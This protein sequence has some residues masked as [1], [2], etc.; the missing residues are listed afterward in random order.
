M[1]WLGR[2]PH[3]FGL[4][5]FAAVPVV[6]A[7]RMGD[8]A[9]VESLDLDEVSE[10]TCQEEQR[11]LQEVWA[12]MTDECASDE[13]QPPFHVLKLNRCRRQMLFKAKEKL[14]V[15]AVCAREEAAEEDGCDGTKNEVVCLARH[16]DHYAPWYSHTRSLVG[17]VVDTLS[18]KNFYTRRN[19]L[20]T[21]G[22]GVHSDIE[23]GLFVKKAVEK[24]G[25]WK[26]KRST[27]LMHVDP[28]RPCA[29]RPPPAPP[30]WCG[31]VLEAVNHAVKLMIPGHKGLTYESLVEVSIE[32]P[33]ED[34][35]R[36][37]ACDEVGCD[38]I[39]VR[40]LVNLVTAFGQP[41][42]KF[43]E[44]APDAKAACLADDMLDA[45]MPPQ[46]IYEPFAGWSEINGYEKLKARVSIPALGGGKHL[47]IGVRDLKVNNLEG[48]VAVFI[49]RE[50]WDKTEK[51]WGWLKNDRN[52]LRQL[53]F[54]GPTGCETCSNKECRDR[55]CNKECGD[56]FEI[57]LEVT[58]ELMGL[59]SMEIGVDLAGI[60]GPLLRASLTFCFRMKDAPIDVLRATPEELKKH[61]TDADTTNLKLQFGDRL[62][63]VWDLGKSANES[64]GSSDKAMKFLKDKINEQICKLITDLVKVQAFNLA[65]VHV[66]TQLSF[67][68][69]GGLEQIF[70]DNMFLNVLEFFNCNHPDEDDPQCGLEIP[71]LKARTVNGL[72]PP[73]EISGQETS[74][75]GEKPAWLGKTGWQ[76]LGVGDMNEEAIR[77]TD[78]ALYKCMRNIK[79]VVGMAR[80]DCGSNKNK[81]TVAEWD[82]R[83]KK[84]KPKSILFAAREKTNDDDTQIWAPDDWEQP[85]WW[86][87]WMSAANYDSGKDV[88]MEELAY[89][90]DL[91][92]GADQGDKDWDNTLIL[93]FHP[94]IYL[95]GH[96]TTISSN[97][98]VGPERLT[99]LLPHLSST[100]D[101]FMGG[102]LKP[103]AQRRPNRIDEVGTNHTTSISSA[104]GRAP[105]VSDSMVR[106]LSLPL[107]H[108]AGISV[109]DMLPHIGQ[110][111]R[112]D[113][114]KPKELVGRNVKL[115]RGLTI[116]VDYILRNFVAAPGNVDH[117]YTYASAP[118]LWGDK[119]VIA[120][121]NCNIFRI[122]EARPVFNDED[123]SATCTDE[124][125]A[126]SYQQQ[127][128]KKEGSKSKTEKHVVGTCQNSFE[129]SLTLRCASSWRPVI[130][131]GNGYPLH[132]QPIEQIFELW[133]LNMYEEVV[134]DDTVSKAAG[135]N[136][137]A[138]NQG[139]WK[140]KR[141]RK[142]DYA[143][144]T[145]GI[146]W[147][148]NIHG[149]DFASDTHDPVCGEPL[150]DGD[151]VGHWQEDLKKQPITAN[152]VH[153]AIKE[154]LS[155]KNG[156]WGE[157]ISDPESAFWVQLEKFAVQANG[158][159]DG[160]KCSTGADCCA[161]DKPDEPQTCLDG[162][163]ATPVS[164][165]RYTP[166]PRCAKYGCYACIAPG[167][168]DDECLL[169]PVNHAFVVEVGGMGKF[170]VNKIQRESMDGGAGGTGAN[171]Q[172]TTAGY[173]WFCLRPFESTP[174]FGAYAQSPREMFAAIKAQVQRNLLSLVKREE[175]VMKYSPRTDP[176]GSGD[177]IVT[178][179][180]DGRTPDTITRKVQSKGSIY[181]ADY[182]ELNYYSPETRLTYSCW[183]HKMM[184]NGKYEGNDAWGNP[185]DNLKRKRD[186]DAFDCGSTIDE[187]GW[188]IM[189]SDFTKIENIDPVAKK[190]E[191]A[192]QDAVHTIDEK[193]DKFVDG[194]MS[195]V[196][197]FKEG[198][199]KAQDWLKGVSAEKRAKLQHRAA[200]AKR[201]FML[202]GR[203]TYIEIMRT[204]LWEPL[205]EKLSSTEAVS[206]TVKLPSDL[207][208]SLAAGSTLEKTFK[209]Y[210]SEDEH[211]VRTRVT[212]EM[213][214]SQK[215]LTIAKCKDLWEL[216]MDER[217]GENLECGAG[218][219]CWSHCDGECSS[220][221]V[222][223]KPG[224]IVTSFNNIGIKDS[225]G[226]GFGIRRE[227]KL[228]AAS[229]TPR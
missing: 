25:G 91:L 80:S 19:L 184:M 138:R 18:R 199:T 5:G 22:Y 169:L 20:W 154:L 94:H 117:G 66:V 203:A 54:D 111:M 36:D 217:E 163:V 218:C 84:W 39:V 178:P 144:K 63:T 124:G 33:E 71:H 132:D 65:L 26:G 172:D 193:M 129:K 86:Q 210:W 101:K 53:T 155:E 188:W 177:L 195:S 82:D 194:F 157:L 192:L 96:A 95:A 102:I 136:E 8:D 113:A 32:L 78:P 164:S 37:L 64:S 186:V 207:K 151:V 85:D 214:K 216:L 2:S 134:P 88:D 213:M 140:C 156:K 1:R 143:R 11:K 43:P 21:S 159:H 69:L 3:F 167:T 187:R 209:M 127:I 107:R 41:E 105:Q 137:L 100:I 202:E 147:S 145:L 87:E 225:C 104:D 165:C 208:L 168:Q 60:V 13:K 142:I 55:L 77:R 44:K 17:S 228:C 47:E 61:M 135:E 224:M 185:I 223:T 9:D 197:D 183:N 204:I 83:S 34:L 99:D 176:P 103:D 97:V 205:T 109:G 198:F 219:V 81:S 222:K 58:L 30:A 146:E 24:Y 130:Q 171:R 73:T 98:Q 150:D 220:T 51:H 40:E 182:N 56:R 10:G 50:D 119:K 153:K 38:E 160:S 200:E 14:A 110:L 29:D 67:V 114:E 28:I 45:S 148:S 122:F 181:G 112:L 27:G 125:V 226:W 128:V 49:P 190:M 79:K 174:E 42:V 229:T 59:D 180:G 12:E 173:Q 68:F 133:M 48:K 227:R 70:T 211:G 106:P 90:I 75:S 74:Q 15:E 115:D 131:P 141:N 4:L 170:D 139:F 62:D 52:T 6:L 158:V 201:G 123:K 35:G 166:R 191:R 16:Y 72:I 161:S 76:A 126:C 57:D 196:D 215:K 31:G 108:W 118:M 221:G 206:A 212:Q 189:P 120:I 46:R 116:N 23:K 93:R 179:H 121:V 162:Y 175:K 152:D 149:L 7:V 89:I 92:S